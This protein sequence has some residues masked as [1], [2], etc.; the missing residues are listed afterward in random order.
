MERDVRV[1]VQIRRLTKLHR[2]QHVGTCGRVRSNAG[3]L[4]PWGK[5]RRQ[6]CL[7][8]GKR[9]HVSQET[10]KYETFPARGR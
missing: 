9:A 2:L 4:G 10:R 5:E 1:R 7:N 3:K 8:Y 6:F